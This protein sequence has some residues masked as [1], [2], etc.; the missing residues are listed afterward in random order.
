MIESGRH[1]GIKNAGERFCPFC[2]GSVENE[3]H[4]LFSC[5]TYHVQRSSFLTPV[6]GSVHG[7]PVLPDHQKME[8]VMSCMD[9]NICNY[10]SNSMD[11]REFLVTKPK[12]FQ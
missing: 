3:S 5:P 8:L 2:P 10:I 6:T 12:G 9:Q 4:F 11:V 1:R 7:F